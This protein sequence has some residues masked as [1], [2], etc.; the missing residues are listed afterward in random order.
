M[1][2]EALELAL[3]I[4]DP[5]DRM[6]TLRE[7]V[8]A[9]ALRSLHESRA[10][11]AIS[12]VG[13]TALRFLYGL[14]RYSE[15]LDFSV[16]AKHGYR[17][18]LWL[19]KLKRDLELSGFAAEVSWND[20]PTVQVAWI[21]IPDLLQEAG[22]VHRRDQKLAIKLEIDTTP[23]EGARSESRIVN[24]FFLFGL[25]YH[26]LPS[27]MAGKI[28]ALLTRQFTKGRDWYDLLWYRSRRP[29]VNPNLTLLEAALKQ[30]GTSMPETW[31]AAILGKI[32]TLD[33]GKVVADVAPFLERR[34][35]VDL[36]TEEA[37]VRC[38][39]EQS[40]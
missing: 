28:N 23:P 35:E 11:E 19:K 8:Q 21:R 17:P 37:F 24:R 27:L 22:L 38:L 34:A 1:K 3:A 39:D 15:D 9:S 4:P 14:P 40:Y 31:Q 30:T 7:Y 16:E 13:G 26:D 6:N 36:L 25:R 33:L 12:F 18:E 29:S 10:F 5:V 2:E 32:A 20:R